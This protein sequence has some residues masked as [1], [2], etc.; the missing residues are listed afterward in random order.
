MTRPRAF[1]QAYWKHHCKPTVCAIEKLHVHQLNERNEHLNK[2]RRK[3]LARIRAKEKGRRE[4]DIG[5]R[6]ERVIN[7]HANSGIKLDDSGDDSESK[8]EEQPGRMS[9][10]SH[11][12]LLGESSPG[13]RKM[14]RSTGVMPK[15][16]NDA[17]RINRRTL[18]CH[19][20]QSLIQ[21]DAKSSSAFN[22]SF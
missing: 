8:M 15:I 10:L 6:A 18:I 16:P 13:R 12:Q 14:L 7:R 19:H 5:R 21:K 4:K 9:L 20:G 1:R 3:I 2:K 11:S 17:A 22:A